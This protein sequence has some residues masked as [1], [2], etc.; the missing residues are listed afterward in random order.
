[1]GPWRDVTG[2]HL[3]SGRGSLLGGDTARRARWWALDLACG[4]K[5][6][7]TVRYRALPASEVQRGGTQHRNAD[8]VLPA[9]ERVRCQQCRN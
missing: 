4:H 5:T 8:D 1:M 9:P 7:R 6:E 3:H 2:S